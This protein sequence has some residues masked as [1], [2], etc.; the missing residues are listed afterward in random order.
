MKSNNPSQPNSLPKNVDEATYSK[1]FD[2]SIG[3]IINIVV[4]YDMGWSK[5]GNGRSYD[6]L[7]GYG[8][9][10]GFLSGKILDFATRNRKCKLCS[11]GREKIDHDC[12]ENFRGSAKAMEPDVGATLV[13][14]SNILKSV[15]LNVRVVVGDEDSST[16]ASIRRGR[17]DKIFKLS[18]K[19]HLQK[20]FRGDLYQLKSK[21]K[22]MTKKILFLT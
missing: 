18:D 7:N 12:R 17:I 3:Q 15:G 13:N 11:N 22:E 2:A 8:C 14:G 21:F 19:N 10:I 4:S 16:I 6:S 9:I 20:S 5:R 1:I